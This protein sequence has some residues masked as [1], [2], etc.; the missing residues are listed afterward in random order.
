MQLDIS[1]SACEKREEVRFHKQEREKERGVKEKS[2]CVF[3][4]HVLLK[5][6]VSSVQK[7]KIIEREVKREK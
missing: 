7:E 6:E 2:R 1:L 4:F 3:S 5:D